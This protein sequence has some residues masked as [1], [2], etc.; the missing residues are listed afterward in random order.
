MWGHQGTLGREGWLIARAWAARA[1][2]PSTMTSRSRSSPSPM[3]RRTLV[4]THPTVRRRAG[5]SNGN[6]AAAFRRGRAP[7][8]IWKTA[9]V[10]RGPH[11]DLEPLGGGQSRSELRIGHYRDPDAPGMWVAAAIRN[12][13][14]LAKGFRRESSCFERSQEVSRGARGPATSP[15]LS[16]RQ[17][18]HRRGSCRVAA[19]TGGQSTRTCFGES[20]LRAVPAVQ[21]KAR[22]RGAST[23]QGLSSAGLNGF[24]R[25]A[26]VNEHAGARVAA[27]APGKGGR[28]RACSTVHAACPKRGKQRGSDDGPR[29]SRRPWKAGR[30]SYVGRGPRR[31]CRLGGASPGGVRVLVNRKIFTAADWTRTLPM[32]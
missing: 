32:A 23:R 22:S 5:T 31:S 1:L 28:G 20:I 29:G 10:G 8:D 12:G 16:L 13:C 6:E 27:G 4:S 2:D 30:G 17:R 21:T 9:N 26:F 11:R 3:I 19:T 14:G 18:G 25:Q 15:F 7:I 24:V